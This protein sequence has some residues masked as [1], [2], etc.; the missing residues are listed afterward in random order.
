MLNLM[1]KFIYG[2][3]GLFND[4]CSSSDH[5]V[6]NDAEKSVQWGG[7]DVKRSGSMQICFIV[8]SFDWVQWTKNDNHPQLG[9]GKAVPLEAW[10]GLEVSR[11]LRFPDFMTTAQDGGKVVSL[12]HRPSLTPGNAPGTHFC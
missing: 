7:K 10:S 8:P 4:V 6:S 11:K 12:M 1:G 5:T 9:K 2:F 3:F